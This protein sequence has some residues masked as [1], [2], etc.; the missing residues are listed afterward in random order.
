[1]HLVKE[2][3]ECDN[4]ADWILVDVSLPENANRTHIRVELGYMA[5]DFVT[6]VGYTETDDG[7]ELGF[8]SEAMRDEILQHLSSVIEN[9]IGMPDKYAALLVKKWSREGR[10]PPSANVERHG[11]VETIEGGGAPARDDLA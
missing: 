9:S 8:R 2:F 7:L 3:K 10:F 6:Q 1:M 11:Y 5:E 4:D